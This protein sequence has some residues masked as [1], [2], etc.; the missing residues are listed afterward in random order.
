MQ[1]GLAA[2]EA[3]SAWPTLVG[4]I[5]LVILP[6]LAWPWLEK[7]PQLRSGLV[8]ACMVLGCFIIGETSLL[9]IVPPGPGDPGFCTWLNEQQFACWFIEAMWCPCWWDNPPMYPW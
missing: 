2:C 1:W 6:I 5:G 7:Y 8:F 4:L 3:Y 9:A